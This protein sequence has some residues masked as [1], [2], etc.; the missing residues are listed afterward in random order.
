[1]TPDITLGLSAPQAPVRSPWLTARQA[2]EYLQ[3]EPR[4]LLAWAREGKVKGHTLSGT[5]RH[6][7]RFRVEDLDATLAVT[8][9][10]HDCV[11]DC[12]SPSVALG[13]RRIQ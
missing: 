3:V 5:L 6:V 4:T 12:N 2:A 11:L 9:P 13:N 1:M 8:E 10:A 7:W